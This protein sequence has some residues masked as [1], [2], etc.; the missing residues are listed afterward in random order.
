MPRNGLFG[1]CLLATMAL[2]SGNPSLPL[3]H[4]TTT[5]IASARVLDPIENPLFRHRRIQ[6]NNDSF[7]EAVV[8]P[9]TEDCTEEASK[10]L[11]CTFSEQR[12]Y[13]ACVATGRWQKFKCSGPDE[14][15]AKYEM[16]SC[17]HTD[18]DNG[19]V[20][21]QFQ[22]FCLLIGALSIVSVKKQKKLSLSM[23][24][25]RKQ[26]GKARTSDTMGSNKRSE[27][28][29]IEFTPMTNQQR[30]RVPLVQR[31]DSMDSTMEVI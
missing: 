13:D 15:E 29:G 31:M 25:R 2:L 8:E 30:E 9:A 4:A 24:D 10:C 3:A 22:I 12:T 6:E 26:Q 14:A 16:R 21:F 20:M 19:L 1:A 23:F 28:D 27:E 7:E 11:Q 18:F 5:S 17:K